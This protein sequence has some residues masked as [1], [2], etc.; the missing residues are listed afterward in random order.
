LSNL[1][2]LERGQVELNGKPV[3]VGHRRA[4][5]DVAVI[6]ADRHDSGCVLDMTIAENLALGRTK[7]VTRR[8]LVSR[9]RLREQ[10][11]RLVREFDVVTPSVDLPMRSLS[12]GNQQ[13]VV[14]ARE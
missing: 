9:R 14:L 10:A 8:G 5:E 6:P 4:L 11:R 12:G 13:R 1:H 2:S 3:R 7:A